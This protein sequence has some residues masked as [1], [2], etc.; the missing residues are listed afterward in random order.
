MLLDQVVKHKI[1]ASH[2]NNG[3][4]WYRVRNK[5]S[6]VSV[7][8]TE[9]SRR[10]DRVS[11][12]FVYP[13]STSRLTAKEVEACKHGSTW[14]I[15]RCEY[16]GLTA[17]LLHFKNAVL[18]EDFATKLGNDG[19]LCYGHVEM[20]ESLLQSGSQIST[21]E[22]LS[23]FR[24][25]D[26]L[27]PDLG[28]IRDILVGSD[29]DLLEHGSTHSMMLESLLQDATQRWLQSGKIRLGKNQAWDAMEATR[30]R[31]AL[32]QVVELL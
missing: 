28:R 6:W 23:Q 22:H 32:G 19:S 9:T 20:T 21:R 4:G 5:R 1:S 8:S 13:K 11:T 29:E 2:F 24:L 18:K 30:P 31:S 10:L 7:F 26:A 15:S 27:D 12:I 16:T 17:L 25:I 14:N 3:A